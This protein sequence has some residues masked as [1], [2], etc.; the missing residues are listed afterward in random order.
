MPIIY[1]ANEAG[2]E[3]PSKFSNAF[4]SYTQMIPSEYRYSQLI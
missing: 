3:N 4:K 1:I 2:Y